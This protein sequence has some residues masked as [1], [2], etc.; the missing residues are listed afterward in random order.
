VT[1]RPAVFLDR[2]GTMVEDPGHL[3]DPD[4]VV[5]LEGVPEAIRTLAEAG[6]AP[7]V[8][9]NQAGVARGLFTE[10]AVVAVN[11]RVAEIL[12]ESDAK[13]EGWY[14]CPHHPD[15]TGPCDCRKPAPGLL[16]RAAR[17]LGLDLSRSWLVGDHGSDVEAA[18]RAGVRP[19][20]VLTGHGREESERVGAA[21]DIPVVANLTAA[22]S[23]IVD[24][25]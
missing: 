22:A 13:V 6:F 16:L 15:F 18:R 14:W 8:I 20:M 5:V 3:G 7:V 24:G 23:W 10:E 19:V 12:A 9:S 1:V 21:P 11:E 25:R 2:D 4:G 17:E